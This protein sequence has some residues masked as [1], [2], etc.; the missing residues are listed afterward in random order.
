MTRE[1]SGSSEGRERRLPAR[2]AGRRQ[3]RKALVLAVGGRSGRFVGYVIDRQD[4]VRG[5]EA[6]DGERAILVLDGEAR[7]RR[8]LVDDGLAQGED[9]DAALQLRA[10]AGT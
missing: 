10:A 7:P 3:R 6:L 2:D 9:V 4:D 1:A 5:G 8:H